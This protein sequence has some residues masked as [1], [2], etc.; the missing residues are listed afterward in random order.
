MQKESWKQLAKHFADSIEAKLV[1][2]D[3][4][5]PSTNGTTITLPSQ[6]ADGMVDL[7]LGALLHETNRLRFTKRHNMSLQKLEADVLH[8]I[9]GIRV[10]SKSLKKYPKSLYFYQK[11]IQNTLDQNK[12]AF[13]GEEVPAKLF[14]SLIFAGHGFDPLSI[15]NPPADAPQ[16]VK[17]DFQSLK[18]HYIE[19]MFLIDQIKNAKSTSELVPVA[20]DLTKRL[21]KIREEEQE[22]KGQPDPH[23]NEGNGKQPDGEGELGESGEGDNPNDGE[24]Q[25]QEC[26]QGDNPDAEDGEGEPQDGGGG[27]N[28]N[29]SDEGDEG[30]D[31]QPEGG[32]GGGEDQP[33]EEEKKDEQGNGS[34]DEEQKEEP[35]Q[36][37]TPEQK[38]EDVKKEI[39][40]L[41][42]EMNDVRD[43]HNNTAD[44][45]EKNKIQ[46]QYESLYNSRSGKSRESYE[47]QQEIQDNIASSVGFGEVPN[48][49]GFDAL[50]KKEFE[51]R[52][53]QEIE[54][55]PALDALIKDA[56][57]FKQEEFEQ[58]E[59]GRI[60]VR[61]L[62]S[63][64]TDPDI[65]FQ[66]KEEH[67]LYTKVT[68]V[69]DVSG[70]MGYV[71]EPDEFKR[72]ENYHN[73]HYPATIAVYPLNMLIKAIRKANEEGHPIDMAVFAFGTST[74]IVI[75][76][77]AMCPVAVDNS[78]W[79][80]WSS[81]CG[82]GTALSECVRVV[83]GQLDQDPSCQNIVFII[84][85]ADVS[86]DE[87]FK[88]RNHVS[89]GE[90]KVVYL[91]VKGDYGGGGGAAFK[92][93][94]GT[95][96]LTDVKQ[97]EEVLTST[98]LASIHA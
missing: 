52:D 79:R 84:T 70:S 95:N 53:V 4:V 69:L 7:C 68:F 89:V 60:N 21:L 57:I 54:Y 27:G 61:H 28:G 40:E 65:L 16:N 13:M 86:D 91:A 12:E 3:N 93:I 62:S 18:N 98:L 83:V 14:K 39:E 11:Q 23:G 73:Q 63:L 38:L 41:T 88:M 76:G 74:K 36:E 2:E 9:E 67:Q 1:F 94:F 31:K 64:Y 82:G 46:K 75:D 15:Y 50:D 80:D 17:D 26:G 48:L 81:Q 42:K 22:R 90:A 43:K 78:H 56:L 45:N 33:K 87:L 5:A 51:P 77:I 44:N 30:E 72:N 71:E 47:L 19:N 32:S 59:T 85:D 92:E 49:C 29:G 10:D 35:P 20:Q 24:G 6:M 37:K 96:N 55:K 58:T 97:C 8:Q 25:G 66:E 34:G